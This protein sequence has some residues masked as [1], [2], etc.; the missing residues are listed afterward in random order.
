VGSRI[1]S[2]SRFGSTLCFV[3]SVSFTPRP[4]HTAR[5]ITTHD[6]SLVQ[7]ASM[8]LLTHTFIDIA[9]DWLD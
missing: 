5:P 9:T 7:G 6:G 2:L 3:V 4:G 1:P 8:E